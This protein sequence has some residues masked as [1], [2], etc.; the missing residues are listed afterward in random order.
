M[1][2]SNQ[3]CFRFIRCRSCVIR[4]S[5][6]HQCE[7]GPAGT[8]TCACCVSHSLQP[9]RRAGSANGATISSNSLRFDEHHE[10]LLHRLRQPQ[11]L[12]VPRRDLA[13]LDAAVLLV[14]LPLDQPADVQ[15]HERE[16]LGVGARAGRGRRSAPSW[17]A[18]GRSTGWPAPR[19]RWRC[20]GSRSPRSSAPRRRC[21]RTSPLPKTG[22]RST[23]STTRRMPSWFTPPEKPCSRVRPWMV[24]AATPTFS[25]SR[26]KYGAVRLSSSH[27]SRIFTR[28]RHR[29]RL[30]HL[31]HQVDRCAGGV[32]H[33]RRPAAGLHDL[34]DRAAHVDVDAVGE[35]ALDE[36]LR[37]AGHL[38]GVRA[39]DLHEQRPL[40]RRRWRATPSSS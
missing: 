7:I 21:D 33:H 1:T 28:D 13:E 5:S 34:A 9:A 25:N 15:P 12:R 38:L 32:A 27:P 40:G 35:A 8:A 20:R 22:I 10:P 36:P 39:E 3:S 4:G 23:A 30:H 6:L 19:G 2:G 24:T 14:P 31:P 26:A 17:R 16:P 18:G 11:R 29:H 37:R